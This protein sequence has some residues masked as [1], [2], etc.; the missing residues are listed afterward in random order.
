MGLFDRFLKR[1]NKKRIFNKPEETI[2]PIIEE[3]KEQESIIEK[4][5]RI[6]NLTYVSEL[7]IK[8]VEDNPKLV[9]LLLKGNISYDILFLL[10]NNEK[11][12][13]LPDKKED[14]VF[15]EF[16]ELEDYLIEKSKLLKNI[17]DSTIIDSKYE[18]CYIDLDKMEIIQYKNK[19]NSFIPNQD[20]IIGEETLTRTPIFSPVVIYFPKQKNKIVFHSFECFIKGELELDED[21][22]IQMSY[23]TFRNLDESIAR[24]IMKCKIV[25]S[26]DDIIDRKKRETP[27]DDEID[28]RLI[29]YNHILYIVENS[30]LDKETKERL[31]YKI[32]NLYKDDDL[33]SL[34]LEVVELITPYLEKL[35]KEEIKRLTEEFEQKIDFFKTKEIKKPRFN[36]TYYLDDYFHHFKKPTIREM[37]NI[38]NNQPAEVKI[39]ILKDPR[40][41]EILGIPSN[42]SDEQYQKIC[43]LLAERLDLTTI[44]FI[45]SHSFD[46]KKFMEDP[47]NC[48][49][50]PHDINP[51]VRKYGVFDVAD[52]IITVSIADL[53]ADYSDE[54]R[55]KNILETFKNFFEKKGDGYH[56][57]SL[58]LLEYESGEQLLKALERRN[59][60]T[61]D[62][63]VREID[64]GKYMIDSNG[65]HRFTILRFHFLL[66]CMKKEKSEEEL[67]EIYKIPVTLSYKLNYF[68]T[69]C[70]YLIQK[71]DP[72]VSDILFNEDETTIFHK[73]K[74]SKTISEEEL[75]SLV[76]K[77]LEKLDFESLKE[78]EEYYKTI[79]SFHEFIDKYIPSFFNKETNQME[80]GALK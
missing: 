9:E 42:L 6:N 61:I 17:I 8:R 16:F 41:L 14:L 36:A 37:L 48:V 76:T 63:K 71:G 32:K 26:N 65:L 45:N 30:S 19:I 79:P 20:I 44:Q 69:Y 50:T 74:S 18:K 11:L 10:N 56:T 43:D 72:S 23:Y 7:F 39:S 54:N 49:Q 35:D 75:I 58:G 67:R 55:G 33:W 66:D 77:S 31:M 40:V 27:I 68:K 13:Y 60:D 64:H 47:A 15:I 57:R 34:D 80:E 29:K 21:V 1:N 59:Q 51:I 38:I 4:I 24:K 2:Q 25:F 12:P 5:K 22:I 28:Y 70:N 46:V 52:K 53:V 3:K 62:M 78:I 73:D